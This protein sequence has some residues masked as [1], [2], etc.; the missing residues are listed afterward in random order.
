MIKPI[1]APLLI[2]V[3]LL[4]NACGGSTKANCVG[5]SNPINVSLNNNGD[6]GQVVTLFSH[7]DKEGFIKIGQFELDPYEVK[8]ICL[9]KDD[10]LE[11][12]LFVFNGADAYGLT[13]ES[14]ESVQINL[15]GNKYQIISP[16]QLRD[17]IR[18]M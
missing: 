8:D 6:S 3:T 1:K 7:S 2:L 16:E 11:N 9:D 17:L 10:E 15:T 5:A 4:L 18:A 13:L 12:G 14:K